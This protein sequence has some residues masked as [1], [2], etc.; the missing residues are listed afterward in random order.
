MMTLPDSAVLKASC[1]V[2]ADLPNGRNRYEKLAAGK[3][4]K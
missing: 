3:S 4:I 2:S 1:N